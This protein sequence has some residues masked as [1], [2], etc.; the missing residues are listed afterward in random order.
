MPRKGREKKNNNCG[1]QKEIKAEWDILPNSLAGR[2]WIVPRAVQ[3]PRTGWGW[4]TGARRVE[5]NPVIK[6]NPCPKN[7]L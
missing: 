2:D 7:F 4:D 6:K 5:A 1:G 3:S